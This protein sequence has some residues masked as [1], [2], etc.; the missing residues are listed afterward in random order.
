[1]ADALTGKVKWFNP[2]KGYGFVQA[3]GLDKDVFL[4]VKNLRASGIINALPDGTAIKF[5]CNDGPKGFFATDIQLSG[6]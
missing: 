6:G 3:D 2:E 1:M 5:V 4:H